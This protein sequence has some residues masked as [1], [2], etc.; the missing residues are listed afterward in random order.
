MFWLFSLSVMFICTSCSQSDDT[1]LILKNAVARC[2]SIEKGRYDMTRSMKYMDDND[3]T[4]SHH[5]C[6]FRKVKNDGIFGFYFNDQESNSHNGLTYCNQQIYFGDSLIT[7]YGYD[8]TGTIYDCGKWSD[9]INRFK[10]NFDFFTLFT[11][12]NCSPLMKENASTKLLYDFESSETTFHGDSCYLVKINEI[13]DN[14]KENDEDYYKSIRHEMNFWILKDGFLPVQYSV[15]FDIVEQ[16]D[17]LYQ[18]ELFTLNDYS[19]GNF[20][21]NLLSMKA[22]PENVTLKDYEPY[23]A[24]ELLSEDTLA[25]FWAL[26]DLNGDTISLADLKG[27][28]VLIDFFYKSC[29]Y[30]CMAFPQLENLY[31]KY[32]DKDFVMFGI[33]PMDDPEKDQMADFLAKRNVTYPVLFSDRD[34]PEEYNVTA[35]P[36]LYLIGKDGTILHNHVGYSETLEEEIGAWIEEALQK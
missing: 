24:P 15:A 7:C 34:L 32:K 26:P 2:Q 19:F 17:T 6:H 28:V 10:H 31:D 30:C 1:K 21:E 11:D 4:V 36:T 25:P 12:K 16:N 14:S 5:A 8:S 22:V 3:T 9:D 23:V 29:G 13:I 18:Y 20:D 33:D 35:Y 27:K